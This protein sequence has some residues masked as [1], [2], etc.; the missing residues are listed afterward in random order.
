MSGTD[1][2]GCPNCGS[3]SL[4][5]IAPP[6]ERSDDAEGLD[7]HASGT[8]KCQRCGED[9]YF[10]RQ[11]LVP[12]TT[13]PKFSPTAKCPECRSYKTTI[14]YTNPEKR[15]RRHKCL[16]CEHKFLTQKADIR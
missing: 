10:E 15:Q 12:L 8:F 2:D 13:L 7:V 16:N 9:H 6:D 4:L 14:L 1:D 3:Q 5:R 11:A